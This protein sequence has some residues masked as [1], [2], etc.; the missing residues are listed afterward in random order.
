MIENPLFVAFWKAGK[1]AKDIPKEWICIPVLE[2]I[3]LIYKRRMC[4]EKTYNQIE[5]DSALAMGSGRLMKN[6]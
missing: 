3:D 6:D 4:E 1:P 5:F 2:V